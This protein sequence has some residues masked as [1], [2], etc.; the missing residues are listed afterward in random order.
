[1]TRDRDQWWTDDGV[2]ALDVIE[3]QTAVIARNL[4]LLRRRGDIYGELDK[5]SYLLMRTLD[6][7]G[8]ADIATLAAKLGL[9]P[10][11]VGRQVTALRAHG[12]VER[13]ADAQDRR[14]G[15]VSA[16]AEGRE[17]L[18]HTRV[19]RRE[20]T[21]E[22]LHGWHQDELHALGAMLTK[23]NRAVARDYLL[24]APDETAEPG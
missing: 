9:D 20:R 10:S 14:R 11:T 3:V 23:Y 6:A 18:A 24:S 15:I 1:M 12:L 21:A 4:E 22:L 19:Q 5:A 17:L 16:T 2:D 13:T 8:P 7:I